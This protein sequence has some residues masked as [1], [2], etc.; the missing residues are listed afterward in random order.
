[1]GSLIFL[2]I[3]ILCVA[4]FVKWRLP[5]WIGRS[6]EKLVSN[7]LHKLDPTHYRILNDLMLPSSGNSSVTQI[8]HIVISNFG[9]F[10]IE[11]KAYKGWILGN[12]YDQNWTQVI[13]HYKKVFYNPLRQ[14]FA[15]IKAIENLM[16]SQRLKAGVISLVVFPDARKLKIYG[17]DSVGY[18]HDIVKKI[19]S[20]TNVIY[21][22]VERDEIFELLGHSNIIDKETRK[23]HNREVRE[24]KDTK[25]AAR[26]RNGQK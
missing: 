5:I 7:K 3:V 16:G 9:I 20:Y 18:P 4:L 24:L 13:Y 6:G 21:S 11:T 8:D 15:H 12:A 19:E 25:L 22:D 2:S 23:I 26:P 17:A 14:N 1:M 10:C